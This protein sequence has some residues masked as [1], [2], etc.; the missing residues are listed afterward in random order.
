MIGQSLFSRE[1]QVAVFGDFDD[2]FV[3]VDGLTGRVRNVG[4]VGRTIVV[5]WDTQRFLSIAG[6]LGRESLI[7]IHLRDY[8]EPTDVCDSLVVGDFPVVLDEVW[9]AKRRLIPVV[10]PIVYELGAGRA[11]QVDHVVAPG[12]LGPWAFVPGVY[13]DA[14]AATDGVSRGVLVTASGGIKMLETPLRMA[15]GH[16]DTVYS[17]EDGALW[18]VRSG[19]A[20]SSPLPRQPGTPAFVE[21]DSTAQLVL[22]GYWRRWPSRGGPATDVLV[23]DRD[24]RPASVAT[25]G[26]L[27]RRVAPAD[28]TLVTVDIAGAASSAALRRLE[29]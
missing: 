12:A 27:T 5:P 23:F 19:V 4:T 8:A 9:G 29:R 20:S 3:L 26:S 24:G 1:M 11:A 6:V 25:F 28:S 13:E 18:T 15:V 16:G 22:V 10:Y 17:V 7:T 21:Y 2:R 14:V